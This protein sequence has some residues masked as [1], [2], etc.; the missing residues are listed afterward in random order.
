MPSLRA[1]TLQERQKPA[2]ALIDGELMCS[3]CA[4]EL[5]PARVVD[6]LNALDIER[7]RSRAVPCDQCGERLLD[8]IGR[9]VY[10]FRIDPQTGDP[11]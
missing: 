2:A 11:T 8:S 9:P 6:L 3:D 4:G 5:W 10:D 1:I 7:R